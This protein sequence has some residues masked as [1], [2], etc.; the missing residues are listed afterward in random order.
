M[1]ISTARAWSFII[2]A[3]VAS[4]CSHATP[5]ASESSMTNGVMQPLQRD[6]VER[7][8]R[9]TGAAPNHVLTWL[10]LDAPGGPNLDPS[11]VVQWVDY[12]MTKQSTS[13]KAHSLGMKTIIY[14]D[15]NR[16]GPGDLMHT[17]Y[18]NT[19]AHDCQ[20][21]R[22]QVLG[23]DKQLMN[24]YSQKLWSLWP[25]AVTQMIGW[26]GGGIYDYIFEDTA[27]SV[28]GLKLSGLPCHFDQ[29]GWTQQT[30]NLDSNL[31]YPIIYN[32]L[33]HVPPG[34]ETP[35]P[36][37]GINPTSNG[38][39]AEDCYVGRTP[40]GYH[41]APNWL[42]MENT[43][44][45]MQ[46]QGRIF[47]C[48]G[49]AYV[50]ASTNDPLRLYFYASFLLSYDLG[51]SIVNTEF[52][53]SSGVTVMPEAELV[54]KQP[55]V[56]TPSDISGLMESSGVYGREYSSCYLLGTPIGA[57]AVAVNPNNPGK[58]GPLAFPWPGKYTHTL[59][60]SGSG[61]YDGGTVAT[62]GPAPPANMSGGTAVIAF[63]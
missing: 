36:A 58:G 2:I 20:G 30:N 16:T 46:A 44:L 51:S 43:E 39:M 56:Q 10:I 45:A 33:S 38:G 12:T 11:K 5:A 3:F 49:D 28:D 34:T 1:R 13:K 23:K 47:I 24:P 15:P 35:A 4:G 19:Y 60:M 62:N 48:H 26:D 8:D 61:V 6:Q 31:G 59:T 25:W 27:D 17:N 53:T 7:R 21:N 18:E 55:L 32:G 22:I 57:C 52:L 41:Y 42:G 29:S 63:P 50:D 37:I 14:T 9:A 54:P 40:S